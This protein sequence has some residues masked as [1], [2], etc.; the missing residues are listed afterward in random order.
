MKKNEKFLALLLS[1][2][3][4]L[5]CF[6][7][8]VTVNA[9][10]A[11]PT[12]TI[13]VTADAV[14]VGAT[15]IPVTLTVTSETGINEAL[16]KVSSDL[17]DII[18]QPTVEANTPA[19]ADNTEGAANYNAFYLS[20]RNVDD[21]T[22]NTTLGAITT[23]TIKVVFTN[24]GIAAGTYNVDVE[25]PEGKVIAA[26]KDE[27]AIKLECTKLEIVVE[28]AVAEHVHNYSSY[29]FDAD[30]H[31]T[32]CANEDGLCDAVTTEKVAHN[33]ETSVCV[34]GYKIDNSVALG[35]GV[36]AENKV[37]VKLTVPDSYVSAYAD[38]VLEMKI[39]Y[40]DLEN[41]VDP[42]SYNTKTV[43]FKKEATEGYVGPTTYASSQ[44]VYVHYVAAYEYTCPIEAKI[45]LFD[46]TGKEVAVSK[47]W[48]FT[49]SNRLLN[50]VTGKDSDAVYVDLMNYGAAVQNYFAAKYPDSDLASAQLPTVGYE[51][52][53]GL[54]TPDSV[55][56]LD[57]IKTISK[58]TPNNN[59]KAAV[60]KGLLIE[61]SNIVRFRIVPE[62]GQDIADLTLKVSFVDSIYGDQTVEVNGSD[63]V[64]ENVNGTLYYYYYSRNIALYDTEAKITAELYNGTSLLYTRLYSVES[65]LNDVKATASEVCKAVE[66][67][68]VSLWDT[69]PALKGKK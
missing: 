2:V 16:I 21:G 36:I 29:D 69:L 23:A 52:Y 53:S 58:G 6:V 40:Y 39:G 56:S 35:R 55:A 3:M 48:T 7:G 34:C 19:D 54:A 10:N 44:A 4:I 57:T 66:K 46:K 25:I 11:T 33:L 68:T 59:S 63:F 14:E 42:F 17:G 41:V 22:G 38:Y 60:G 61:D 5:T 45:H 43:L 9:E 51:K 50:S 26:S 15:E 12:A 24:A 65:G 32:V 20:A 49:V 37:G 28:E 30:A 47:T 8:T 13:V 1:V 27:V 18:A 31:W 67:L 62:A 64:V